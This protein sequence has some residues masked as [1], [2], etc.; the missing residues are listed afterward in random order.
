MLSPH[1]PPSKHKRD[2]KIFMV[3]QTVYIHGR[4]GEI[5]YTQ[6]RL[7]RSTSQLLILERSLYFHFDNVGTFPL[8]GADSKQT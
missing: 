2:T 7:Q 3:Q 1:L 4:D 6:E 8:L 5:H